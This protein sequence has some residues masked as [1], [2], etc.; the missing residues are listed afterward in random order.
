MR[1]GCSSAP[2]PFPFSCDIRRDSDRTQAVLPGQTTQSA[3]FAQYPRERAAT[4]AKRVL[5]DKEVMRADRFQT[6]LTGPCTVSGRGYWTG[7]INTLTFLPAP[8]GSGVRFVRA[9]LATCPATEALSRHRVSQPLRTL[10]KQG[11]CEVAMIEHVMAA[12]YGMRIDNVEVHCTAPEMPGLDGSS[13][14]YVLAFEHVGRTELR[15]RRQVLRVREPIRLG[16]AQQWILVEPHK[17]EVLEVEYR[18]D[19]GTSSPIGKASYRVV[20]NEDNFYHEVSPARTFINQADAQAL[21]ASGLATHVTH[22]DLLVFDDHG[23]VNNSLRF[24]DECARHKTLDLIGDLALCGVDLVGRV[25]AYRSGHH[26]NGEMAEQLRSLASAQ[27]ASQR[28]A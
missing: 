14:A 27:V 3:M 6:T 17:E 9:D 24:V 16:N 19:F 11:Q 22:R 12:L 4:G 28:A 18:L 2:G 13:L 20:L 15:T 7:K 25:T 5:S 26:L 21:Q 1:P 10:L 8:A 23:P